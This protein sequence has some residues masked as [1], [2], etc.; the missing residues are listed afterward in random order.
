MRKVAHEARFGF[1]N[2]EK[3]TKPNSNTL[4]GNSSLTKAMIAQTIGDLVERQTLTW[5][6]PISDTI[7]E[8]KSLDKIMSECCTVTDLLSHRSGLPTFNILWYQGNAM[9]LVPK[10]E[11]FRMDGKRHDSVLQHSLRMEVFKL[12]LRTCGRNHRPQDRSTV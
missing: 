3:T 8:F 11:L 7:P 10:S 12:G 5:N 2:H 9:S 6:E 4:Y 1:R